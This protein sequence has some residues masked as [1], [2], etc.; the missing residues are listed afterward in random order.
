MSSS[1]T[2]R[3]SRKEL[4]RR[5]FIKTSATT[6]TAIVAGLGGIDI[7]ETAGST[8]TEGSLPRPA[9][10]ELVRSSPSV[11]R[12]EIIF[13]IG[14]TLI[15][16]RPGDPGYKDL[17]WY[18]ITE[19]INNRLEALPDADLDG[20]NK[21]SVGVFKKN[22]TELSEDLRSKYFELLLQS[23]SLKNEPLQKK[24]LEVYSNTREVVFTVFYQNFPQNHWPRDA[25]RVPILRPGDDHQITNPNSSAIPT[26][27]DLAGYAGPLTWEEE[28]RRR[29][30]FKKINWVNSDT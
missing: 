1:G 6:S 28:E 2:S 4:S 27:W 7:A 26:G 13:A 29:K 14:D 25:N 15:P 12:R 20:F 30:Y 8:N 21:S 19:E 18:G 3:K 10:S 17:E 16:S 11:N 24:L 23:G 22:F 9:A 5:D